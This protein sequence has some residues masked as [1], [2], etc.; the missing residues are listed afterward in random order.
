MK[1]KTYR[2]LKDILSGM[3]DIELDCDLAILNT[4]DSWPDNEFMSGA[5]GDIQLF[6]VRWDDVLD[7]GH[8][9]IH[10]I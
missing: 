6:R 7:K 10:I 4:S 3:S 9:Y 2:E 1:V 5:S 8:P